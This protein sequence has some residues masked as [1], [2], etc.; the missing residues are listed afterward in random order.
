MVLY[1]LVLH[2]IVHAYCLDLLPPKI[3]SSLLDKWQSYSYSCQ[4]CQ[5]RDIGEGEEAG[6]TSILFF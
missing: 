2:G 5:I 4:V 3:W 6:Q 1:G